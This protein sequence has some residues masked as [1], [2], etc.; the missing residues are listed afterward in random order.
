LEVMPKRGRTWTIETDLATVEVVGTAFSVERDARRLRVTVAR[1]I[2]VVRGERVPGRIQRLSAGQSFE[3][4][5]ARSATP[6][7]PGP[8]AEPP[9]PGETG[10][11]SETAPPGETGPPPRPGETGSPQMPRRAPGPRRPS[12]APPRPPPPATAP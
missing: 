7:P 5:E 10:P 6:A 1:G 4:E 3:L 2:V 11:P 8:P 12:P 9:P